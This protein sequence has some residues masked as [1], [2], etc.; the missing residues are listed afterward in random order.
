MQHVSA[1]F[2]RR[3][4]L[5]SAPLL[6]LAV[7][8]C[9]LRSPLEEP[10]T[11]VPAVIDPDLTLRDSA[12]AAITAQIQLLAAVATTQP[13]HAG[14]T[15]TLIVMHRAHLEALPGDEGAEP[16]T[17]T[18]TAAAEHPPATW[19][20][21]VAGER[22]LQKT[23]GDAAQSAESGPFARLLASM[24]AATGQRSAA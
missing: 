1:T 3:S 10:P 7:S 22:R 8:A 12:R 4:V 13:V 24:A 20:Q 21:A 2:S 17:G 23:L 18:P 9:E 15:A 16:P 6:G 5:L 19:A 14:R 11:S